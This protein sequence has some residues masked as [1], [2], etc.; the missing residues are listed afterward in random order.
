MSLIQIHGTI[1]CHDCICEVHVKELEQRERGLF[2]FVAQSF[3]KVFKRLK[4][5]SS[6]LSGP[7]FLDSYN[8]L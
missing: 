6:D 5:L 2:S 4:A 7:S 8:F 3:N 1:L